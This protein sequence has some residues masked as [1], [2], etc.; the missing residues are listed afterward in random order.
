MALEDVV[1]LVQIA[2]ENLERGLLDEVRRGLQRVEA[3][4]LGLAERDAGQR[5]H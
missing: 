5:L 4:L 1:E 3:D 2:R